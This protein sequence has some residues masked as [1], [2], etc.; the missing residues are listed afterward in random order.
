MVAFPP[1]EAAPV[2]TTSSYGLL[3]N[4]KEASGLLS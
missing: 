2:N 1:A 4:G 3:V